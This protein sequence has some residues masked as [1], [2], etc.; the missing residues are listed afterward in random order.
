MRVKTAVARHKKRRRLMKAAQSFRGTPNNRLRR[1]KD[2]VQRSMNYMFS[3][4]KLRKRDMRAMFITRI[5]AGVRA[6][7]LTYSR[8]MAGVLKA[9]VAL[10]RRV[11]ADLA[12]NEPAAFTRVVE[13]ARAALR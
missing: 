7:G 1:A 13:T 2:S 8:F 4:R 12:L 10:D 6:H 3:G 11:L 5:N 9:G